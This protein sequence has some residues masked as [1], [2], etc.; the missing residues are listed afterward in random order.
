DATEQKTLPKLNLNNICHINVNGISSKTH[1]LELMCKEMNV[2]IL[3]ITEHKLNTPVIARNM[4]ED[5]VCSSIYCRGKK[6]GGGAAIYVKK[7]VQ[8]K[9]FPTEELNIE[10]N[11]ESAAIKTDKNTVICIYRPPKGDIEV[12]YSQLTKCLQKVKSNKNIFICGDMNIDILTCDKNKLSIKKEFEYFL[13]QEGLYTTTD[14]FTRDMGYCKTA[15]DHIITN[16]D[17]KEIRSECNIEAGISD[18]YLQY[19]SFKKNENKKRVEYRYQR[20]YPQPKV[21]LLLRELQDQ[22]WMEVYEADHINDKFTNFHKTFLAMYEKCFPVKRIKIGQEEHKKWVTKG[23]EITSRNFRELSQKVKRSKDLNSIEY[24]KR[25]RIIYRKVLKTAK[26]KYIENEIKNAKNVSKTVWTLINK[27]MGKPEK[28]HKNIKIKL[29]NNTI[30]TDPQIISEEFNKHY[31]SQAEKLQENNKNEEGTV[32]RGKEFSMYLS[33]VTEN[34][35]ILAIAKL[36]NKKCSGY[37]EICDEIVKACHLPL[38]KP[39]K[40]LLILNETKT[41]IVQF[42]TNENAAINN[43]TTF[44]E[45]RVKEAKFLGVYIDQFLRWNKHAEHLIPKLNS[46][47]FGIK[48][49]RDITNEKTALLA[50]HGMFH[51]IISYGTLIWG[52]TTMKQDL[53]KLQKKAIRAV[54]NAPQ[55]ESCKPLFLKG[56]VMT[57]P[58]MYIYDLIKFVKKNE[59]KFKTTAEKHHHNTRQRNQ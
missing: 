33:K 47:I 38:L 4:L 58:A 36:K 45:L 49:I 18:H 39:L 19:V 2:E 32:S 30:S 7:G 57:L 16:V 13:T 40:H 9:E 31:C 56:K 44:T 51:S 15:I 6:G 52:N 35:V 23:I 55:T 28:E 24:F 53:F 50:Y 1:K 25:Y 20:V 34:D 17:N 43:N 41:N 12:F 46:A 59:N 11:F 54:Y 10:G 21:A 14:K 3:C 8:Y 5:Y 48:R 42:R 26:V 22:Q 37:D 29:E 27:N